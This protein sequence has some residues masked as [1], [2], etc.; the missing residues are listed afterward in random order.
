M[1]LLALD[2]NLV[3]NLLLVACVLVFVAAAAFRFYIGRRRAGGEVGEE[4]AEG[5]SGESF[6]EPAAYNPDYPSQAVGEGEK[7]EDVGAGAALID[8]KE[9]FTRIAE[10]EPEA[11]ISSAGSMLDHLRERGGAPAVSPKVLERLAMQ[12]GLIET[13]MKRASY[14]Q[15]GRSCILPDE[16][17]SEIVREGF[18]LVSSRPQG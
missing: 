6:D 13:A 12:F 2:A 18:R 16:M 9:L 15:T 14:D 1:M 11:V 10:D 8:V 7:S 5:F 3:T 4:G 17:M